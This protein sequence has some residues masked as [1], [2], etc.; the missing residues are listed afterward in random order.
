MRSLPAFLISPIPA[1]ALQSFISRRSLAVLDHPAI[2]VVA[3][4]VGLLLVQLVIAAPARWYLAKRGRRSL[5]IDTGVGAVAV[6]LP[7]I[8]ILLLPGNGLP[9]IGAALTLTVFTVLGAIT[10]LT[11][12]L[13][14]LRSRRAESAPTPTD[15]AARFD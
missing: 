1:V 2:F 8:V 13:L 15:L 9:P 4:F 11:Y 14:R 6:M 10:G 12:G 5:W 3:V 7:L